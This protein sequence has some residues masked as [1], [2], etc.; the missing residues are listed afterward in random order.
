VNEEAMAHLGAVAP[1][2][3]NLKLKGKH[4]KRIHVRRGMT[5]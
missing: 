5:G 1:E 4:V 2:I 3:K